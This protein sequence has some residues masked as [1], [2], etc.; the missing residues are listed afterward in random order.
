ME[1]WKCGIDSSQKI[2]QNCQEIAELRR[3]C[4]EETDRARQARIDELSMQQKRN[5][6]TASQLL[7]KIRIK[8]TKAN[9]LSDAENFAILRQRAALECPTFPVNPLLFRVSETCPA[10]TLDCRMMHGILWVLQETFLNDYLLEKDKPL[11]SST[12][13]RIWHFF[14]RIVS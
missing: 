10:A 8:R 9:S 4:C 13:I 3:I 5:P 2:K 11:L 1:N 7:T 6:A 12:S 14:S